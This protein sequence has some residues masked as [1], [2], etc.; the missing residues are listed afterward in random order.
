MGRNESGSGLTPGRSPESD[1][2]R[3]DRI[4]RESPDADPGRPDRISELPTEAAHIIIRESPVTDP[5]RPDRIVEPPRIST[6]PN[7]IIRESPDTDP[8]RPD[9]IVEPPRISTRTAVIQ[10]EAATEIQVGPPR[11][12]TGVRSVPVAI[13]LSDEGIH[14]QVEVA[15]KRWLATADI[16]ADPQASPLWD[17]GSGP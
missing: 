16:S 9:R 14:E 12:A 7:I 13:Y 4:V 3:P 17:R 6:R 1:A 10:V 8:S 11:E 5:D 2:G 15:V